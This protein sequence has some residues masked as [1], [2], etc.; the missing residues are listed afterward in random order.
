[1]QPP[2]NLKELKRIAGTIGIHLKIYIKSL[3]KLPSLHQAVKKGV[4]FVWDSACQEA[5]EEIK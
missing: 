1:M 5:F 3:R 4:Q 2:K